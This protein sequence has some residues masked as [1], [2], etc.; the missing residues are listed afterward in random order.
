MERAMWVAEAIASAPPI[1]IQGTLKAIWT[2]NDIGR[3]NALAQAASIVMLGTVSDN[4]AAGQDDV[5]VE[6]ARVAPAL[7]LA[8]RVSRSRLAV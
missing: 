2:A 1:A 7:T 8:A 3:R 4:L 6:E 5:Q